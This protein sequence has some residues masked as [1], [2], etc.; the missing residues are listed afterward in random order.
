MHTYSETPYMITLARVLWKSLFCVLVCCSHLPFVAA[1]TSEPKPARPHTLVTDHP[2]KQEDFE[3]RQAYVVGNERFIVQSGTA[4][5][6]MKGIAEVR[7]PAYFMAM[8]SD[9]RYQLTPI[10]AHANVYVLNPLRDNT[11]TIAAH[12]YT[13][14]QAEVISWQVTGVRSDPVAKTYP[15]EAEVAKARPGVYIEEDVYGFDDVLDKDKRWLGTLDSLIREFVK[16]S[17]FADK[18][19]DWGVVGSLACG[20]ARRPNTADPSDADFIVYFDTDIYNV[21]GEQESQLRQAQKKYLDLIKESIEFTGYSDLMY[22]DA[23]YFTPECSGFV[24]YSLKD[25]KMYGRA[26]HSPRYI[27]PVFYRGCWY[28]FDREA[29]N[30]MRRN[31]PKRPFKLKYVDE[32]RIAFYDPLTRDVLLKSNPESHV[33]PND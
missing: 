9:F 3:L 6:N 18:V 16:A 21:K 5:L 33:K 8:C 32:N 29:Y 2:N 1:Q 7:L 4:Q 30:E 28:T 26:D 31:N 17:G 23:S 27:K 24:F 15:F 14:G 25:R 20:T 12:E 10:G 13:D 19:I 11:F 22:A